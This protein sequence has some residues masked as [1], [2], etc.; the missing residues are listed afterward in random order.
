MH[1]VAVTPNSG[2]VTALIVEDEFLIAMETEALLT[3]NGY[4]VIGTAAS[5]EKAME[6]L[7]GSTPD[8]AILDMNLRGKSV[9]PVAVL[10]KKRPC[11]L[12]LRRPIRPIIMTGLRSSKM[13]STLESPS[14]K[15]SWWMPCEPSFLSSDHS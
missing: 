6:F 4:I 11:H 1:D 15:K 5:I 7:E 10:L 13:S 9:L 3:E 14:G 8:I 2:A 12:F